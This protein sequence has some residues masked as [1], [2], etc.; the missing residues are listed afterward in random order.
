MR[1]YGESNVPGAPGN[2]RTLEYIPVR[3]GIPS[4]EPMPYYGGG[5]GLQ[6]LAGNP[7]GSDFVIPGAVPMGQ[8]V[9]PGEN[10]KLIESVYG[11]RR[12]VPI[13]GNPLLPGSSQLTIRGV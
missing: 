11:R 2:F 1:Y 6:P 13:Q 10:Q 4:F 3:D 5:M 8:P 9:L 12:P 7:F